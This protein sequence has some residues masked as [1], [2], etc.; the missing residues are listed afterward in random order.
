MYLAPF[1]RCGRGLFSLLE[2]DMASSGAPASG[3]IGFFG[4]LTIV[5]IALKLCGVIDWSWWL[6]LL[7]LYG[8]LTLLLLLLAVLGLVFAVKG[9]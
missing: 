4:L 2:V 7:P 5:F 3:G 6:V 8:P 1:A 9:R